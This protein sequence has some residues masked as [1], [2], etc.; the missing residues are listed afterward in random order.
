MRFVEA[1]CAKQFVKSMCDKR[2]ESHF[3]DCDRLKRIC[4][5]SLLHAVS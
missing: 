3:G 5:S 1:E 2:A 4:L